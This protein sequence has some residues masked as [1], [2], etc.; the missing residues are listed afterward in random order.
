MGRLSTTECTYLPTL[1][2]F[3]PPP[4]PAPLG[5]TGS[6]KGRRALYTA[7]G[8]LVARDGTHG[9]HRGD[10]RGQTGPS[11]T[12]PMQGSQLANEGGQKMFHN[13]K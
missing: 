13:G 9:H 5:A 3:L 4:P 6:E 10:M 7:Q 1:P 12:T 8:W 11:P 2:T